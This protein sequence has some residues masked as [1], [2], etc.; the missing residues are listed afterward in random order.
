MLNMHADVSVCTPKVI[1]KFADIIEELNGEGNI[2][3]L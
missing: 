2:H 3:K 1:K